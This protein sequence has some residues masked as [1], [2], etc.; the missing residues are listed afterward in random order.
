M[1]GPDIRISA[2]LS[3]VLHL[4]FFLLAAVIIRHSQTMNIPSPYIVSLVGP[5]GASGGGEVHE[6]EKAEEK[7]AEPEVK[8]AEKQKEISLREKTDKEKK[9]EKERVQDQIAALKAKKKI[10]RILDLRAKIVSIGKGQGKGT[11]GQAGKG[12]D[13]GGPAGTMFDS[14]YSKI[15]EK[16][17]QEWTWPDSAE[18]NL[19]AII[20]VRIARDGTLT[21]QGIEKSSGNSFFDRSALKALSKASPVQPPPYEMEIG[22]R[23]YP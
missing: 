17:W 15:T 14:Y 10:G 18:K 21:V 13:K 1:K 12:T 19:E 11:A 6:E 16:I 2:A 23:F 22:I 5:S 3:A 20:A 9:A 8:T 7:I 4:I